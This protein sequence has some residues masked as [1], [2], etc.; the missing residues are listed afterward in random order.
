MRVVSKLPGRGMRRSERI[1]FHVMIDAPKCGPY[2]SIVF[3]SFPV[4]NGDLR[5]ASF[6][7]VA[8][9]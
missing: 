4:C 7:V 5:P 3:L 1:E 9:T 6:L 2:F 8:Y